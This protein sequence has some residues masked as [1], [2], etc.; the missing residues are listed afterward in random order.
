M[1]IAQPTT[2]SAKVKLSLSI[3]NL[4]VT[5]ARATFTSVNFNGTFSAFFQPSLT[6]YLVLVG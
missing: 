2:T 5:F 1:G 4:L 3:R 6:T